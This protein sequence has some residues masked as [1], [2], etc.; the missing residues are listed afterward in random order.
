MTDSAFRLRILREDETIDVPLGGTTFRIRK[1]PH[2]KSVELTRRHTR[3]GRLDEDA[4]SQALWEYALAGWSGLLDG[5]GRELPFAANMAYAVAKA[6]PHEV[7]ET[8]L[9]RARQAELHVHEALGNSEPSSPS[10]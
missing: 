6:L 5:D 1:I 4:F 8:L 9:V 2:G 10:A 3:A 7:S